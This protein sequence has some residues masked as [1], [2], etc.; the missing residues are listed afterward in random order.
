MFHWF[1]PVCCLAVCSVVFRVGLC[2]CIPSI[3]VCF[4][5][6]CLGCW[7]QDV[8]CFLLWRGLFGWSVWVG[9]GPSGLVGVG[10]GALFGLGWVVRCSVGGMVLGWWLCARGVVGLQAIRCSIGSQELGSALVMCGE[11]LG[12]TPIMPILVGGAC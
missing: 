7:G 6:V 8:F 3:I 10:S 5:V 11:C 4:G 12:M 1:V 2:R 9:V